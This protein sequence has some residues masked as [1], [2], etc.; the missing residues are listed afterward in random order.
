MGEVLSSERA[1]CLLFAKENSNSLK[2]HSQER[3]M[4]TEC[5]EMLVLTSQNFKNTYIFVFNQA[6]LAA[7]STI[8]GALS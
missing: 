3:D 2:T 8:M 5:T 6:Q 4:E 1:T 7:H